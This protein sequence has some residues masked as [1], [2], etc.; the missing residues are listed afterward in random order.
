MEQEQVLKIELE[1]RKILKDLNIT[2]N[3]NE[4]AQLLNEGI[5]LRRTGITCE[6]IKTRLVFF[7][8]LAKV[9]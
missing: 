4:Y 8:I 7:D 6:R 2:P 9:S 5:E 1:V 3:T